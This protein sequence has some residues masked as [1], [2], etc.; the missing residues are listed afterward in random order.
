MMWPW[1]CS[2]SLLFINT[3]K[4]LLLFF[5]LSVLYS[6]SLQGWSPSRIYPFPPS[7]IMCVRPDQFYSVVHRYSAAVIPSKCT[8]GHHV[9]PVT[10]GEP[11]VYSS[12]KRYCSL[13][14]AWRPFT[15]YTST[16]LYIIY[17][18]LFLDFFFCH[19][20]NIR[21]RIIARE[22]RR[23]FYYLCTVY[24]RA[25]KSTEKKLFLN[26]R[27]VSIRFTTE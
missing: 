3:W 23:Q 4:S 8:I 15:G 26:N 25:V 14:Y 16:V 17:I 11:S 22:T 5:P 12:N 20:Y 24:M 18:Y 10:G 6:H 13:H 21:S 1:H 27:I 9:H 7:P 19:T 2:A